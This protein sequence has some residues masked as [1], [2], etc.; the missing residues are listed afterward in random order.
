[1]ARKP[2]DDILPPESLVILPPEPFVQ[3]QWLSSITMPVWFEGIDDKPTPVLVLQTALVTLGPKTT[4]GHIIEAV[5]VPWLEIA[6]EIERDPKAL[7]AFV[8]NPQKFEEFI[9]GAYLRAGYTK[10]EL[11]PYSGDGGRDVIATMSGVVTVRVLDQVKAYSPGH[12]VDAEAV[13]AIVGVLDR[14]K[15]ASRGVVT[16]TSKF[17]PGVWKEF[18]EYIPNRLDLRD[19]PALCEWLLKVMAEAKE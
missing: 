4:E 18:K 3:D 12:K 19:G 2:D 10:V 7:F 16:T 9:A 1:M 6:R 15:N 5:T 8:S 14:D 17:A 13:R 11:T